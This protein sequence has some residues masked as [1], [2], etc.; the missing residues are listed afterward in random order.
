MAVEIKEVSF[1]NPEEMKQF[2]RFNLELYKGNPYH[3]PGL[4]DD[5]LMTLDPSKNPAFAFCE[6]VYYLAY[7]DGKV[8][9]RIAG[10]INE[11]A[12]SFWNQ[13]NARFG[14]VDFINNDEV[15]DALFAAVTRWAQ[16]K[17]KEMLQGPMGFTDFDHEGMLIKG[18]DQIGTMATIYNY[19][20]YP[21][22]LER[23]GFVKDQDWLE[24]KIF[25]PREIP[26]RHKRLSEI[27]RNKYGLKTLKF[28]KRKEIMPYAHR[29]FETLN[30]SYS[31]L[32]GYSE[33][34]PEQID[35]YVKIYIPMIR[36]EYVT[37]IVREKDDKVVAVAIT[38][39]NLSRALQK[40][41]GKLFPF[42]WAHLLKAM[43]GRSN[44]VVDLYLVAVIPEYQN[45]G[46]NALLFDDLIPIYQKNGIEY[47]ESNPE[48]E[49]NRAVQMQW[50]YFEKKHHKARRAYIKRIKF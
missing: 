10:I 11:R 19:A 24:Y 36:L 9:G 26:E 14:F 3:V 23:L 17:G 27:V 39:P 13:N 7:M 46:V 30:Q 16:D 5:E 47:A 35:H 37:V 50:D 32:Y 12:N 34:T 44:R 29:I 33:L 45:K 43:K 2:V 8:V 6:S 25:I 15:V 28:K 40:A 42:G 18:F 22:Q 20:Y 41:N 21:K 49:T 48:L 1:D 4:I 38:L 31:V